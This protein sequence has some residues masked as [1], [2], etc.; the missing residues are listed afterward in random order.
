[1]DVISVIVAP[2]CLKLP[3]YITQEKGNVV[4][5]ILNGRHTFSTFEDKDIKQGDWNDI[6]LVSEV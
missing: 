1:M 5:H 2:R 4:D 3:T 6:P